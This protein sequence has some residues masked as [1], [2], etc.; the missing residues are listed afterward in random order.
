MEEV[1]DQ[2]R[3]LIEDLQAQVSGLREAVE[4]VGEP[5]KIRGGEDKPLASSR[6]TVLWVD[7]HPKNN[8]YLVQQLLDS[9]IQV[10]LAQTTEDGLRRFKRGHYGLVLSD[11]GRREN[12]HYNRQAGLDLLGKLREIDRE[13]PFFIYCSRRKAAEFESDARQLGATAITSS[14]TE[15]SGLLRA[16]LPW[17]G[18]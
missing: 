12:D 1:N 3:L 6:P 16:Q 18:P 2:Q 10:D 7:D 11:M 4:A 9:G 5:A 8:S 14:A 15:L 13:V 17:F